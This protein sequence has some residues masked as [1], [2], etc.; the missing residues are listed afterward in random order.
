MLA[1]LGSVAVGGA[2]AVS[3]GAF[4]SVQADRTVSVSVADDSDALLAFDASG[5]TNRAYANTSGQAISIDISDSNDSGFAGEDPSGV[6]ADALTQILDIFEVRNQGTQAAVVYVDPTS[7]PENQRTKNP[8]GGFGIDPQASSRPNGDFTKSDGVTAVDDQIS[9]T[10]IYDQDFPS[11]TTYYGGGDDALEE[12]VL[13]PGESF[14]FGLYVD[15]R[16]GDFD[17][18][19]GMEIVA[20]TTIVPGS[21]TGQGQ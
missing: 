16:G 8:S 7:V 1:A 5:S 13:E 14:D 12:Y 20:D 18:S 9:L 6:N 17:G 19:F 3:T 10:H 4:T 21:Y 15:T 2:T 11:G